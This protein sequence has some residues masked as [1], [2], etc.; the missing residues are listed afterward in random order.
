[1]NTGLAVKQ[2]RVYLAHPVPFTPFVSKPA[3]YDDG[4]CVG[5][6]LFLSIFDNALSAAWVI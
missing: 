3:L 5:V 1:V 6:Y 4:S 2:S